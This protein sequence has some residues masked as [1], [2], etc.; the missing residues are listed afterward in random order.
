MTKQKIQEEF[1]YE[2]LGFPIILKNVPMIFIR[3]SW[4][5]DINLNT[6]QKVVLLGLA[7]HKYLLSGNQIRFIR[8]WLGLTQTEFGKLLGVTHPAVVKWEKSGNEPSKMTLAIERDLRF[9]ILD[10][11]LCEDKIFRKAFRDIF[12]RRFSSNMQPLHFDVQKEFETIK[13]YGKLA[14]QSA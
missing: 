2:G 14:L 1:V 10:R 6:F 9:R 3:D 5:L 11:I 4:V 7:F 13:N 12:E 8:L